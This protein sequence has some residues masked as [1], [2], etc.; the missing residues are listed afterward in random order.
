MDGRPLAWSQSRQELGDLRAGALYGE[1][2]A[3]PAQD[4]FGLWNV[5]NPRSVLFQPEELT[6]TCRRQA[7]FEEI[8]RLHWFSIDR[9]PRCR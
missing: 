3:P 1:Y 6:P 8:F 4:C 5:L 9:Q 7:M 2:N